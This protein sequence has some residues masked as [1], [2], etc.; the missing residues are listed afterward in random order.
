MLQNELYSKLNNDT[1]LTDIQIY[2]REVI[3]SRGFIKQTI[4]ENM[5]LLIEETG[6]LAKAIRKNTKGMSVDEERLYKYDTIESEVA[7][8]FIVLLS[9]C[10]NLD[11]NLFNVFMEKEKINIERTWKVN[12]DEDEQL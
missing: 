4:Q 7:D 9:L 5:L 1:S 2:I 8:I 11:L 6:E 12:Q 3:K 10:N